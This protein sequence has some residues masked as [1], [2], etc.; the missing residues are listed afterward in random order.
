MFEKYGEA[1]KRG[2]SSGPAYENAD[3]PDHT[4][5]D[6]FNTELA[7]ATLKDM[8]GNG[9]KAVLLRHGLQTPAPQLGRPQ[10]LLGSLRS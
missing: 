10:A 4:Y 7:I 9:K 8:T 6:G 1:A 2:L 5:P 3:V